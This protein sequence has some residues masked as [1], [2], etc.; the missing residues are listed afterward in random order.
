MKIP[1]WLFI[2]LLSLALVVSACRTEAPV[3]AAPDR[4]HANIL[5]FDVAAPLVS[6][7]PA[8]D[9]AAGA[10]M[11]FPLLYSFLFVNDVNGRLQPDLATSWAYDES[12]RTWTIRLRTDAFF[13]DGQPVTAEDARCSLQVMISK[14]LPKV[15]AS[16][17]EIS[18]P[19]AHTLR[20]RLNK[21][22]PDFLATI[23]DIQVLPASELTAEARSFTPVG[24]GPFVFEAKEGER[25]AVL[26]ANKNYYAGRPALDGVEFYYQPDKE[27]TWTRLL[28]GA[29]DIAQEIAPKNYE[30]TRQYQDRFYFHHNMLTHYAILLYNSHDPLFADERI[31]RALSQAIDRQYIVDQ[32]LK[33]YGRVAIGPMG[34][35]SPFHAPGLTPLDYNPRESL[36]VLHE[37]GWETGEG[38]VL[39]KNGRP[40]A[41]TLLISAE[42][43]VKKAVA[44]YIQLCFNDI[45][46][47]MD[48]QA[49][50]CQ[51]ISAS[52]YRNSDFQAVLTEFPGAYNRTENIIS[53]WLPD[54]AGHNLTGNF[55]H[56]EVTRLLEMALRADDP[57]A[58][59]EYLFQA[60]ALLAELQPGTFLYQQTAFDVMSKRFSL[61]APFFLS[62]EGIY[63]LRLAAIRS[64]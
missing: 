33:G 64:K 26:T 31:R 21:S 37:A 62:N 51:E 4:A 6:M 48:I 1:F 53:G 56:P 20:I 43:Q 29:T 25:K 10:T 14:L 11:I 47:R 49:C 44:R 12:A 63:W 45:G 50:P 27:R 16:I 58:K 35:D 59:K 23:Q 55:S 19:S 3:S 54:E 41:F 32:I 60:D 5:R 22:Y 30:I 28:A 46:I 8:E 57:R 61:S 40:F 52:Y 13:H 9:N 24:S 2:G 42:A 34:V 39:V 17:E 38:G 36:R 15:M 18:I 7:N